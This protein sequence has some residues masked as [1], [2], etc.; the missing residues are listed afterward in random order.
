MFE[1]Y[2]GTIAHAGKRSYEIVK[3]NLTAPEIVILRAI[4]GQDTVTKIKV[5]GKRN[6]KDID[7]LDGDVEKANA[8]DLLT[9]AGEL[10]RLRNEYSSFKVDDDE[11]P[12]VDALWPGFNPQLPVALE[13]QKVLASELA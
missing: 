2:S 8:M 4:H 10:R 5:T 9:N 6:K 12:I 7:K 3:H 13:E 1:L 11:K